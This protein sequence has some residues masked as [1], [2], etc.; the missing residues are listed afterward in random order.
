MP[1]Q[2]G[3]GPTKAEI[4]AAEQMAQGRKVLRFAVSHRL[5]MRIEPL[6]TLGIVTEPYTE[7]MIDTLMANELKAP[8]PQG[9]SR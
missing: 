2:I 5:P 3:R 7:K 6:S 1:E 4:E 9:R 8:R